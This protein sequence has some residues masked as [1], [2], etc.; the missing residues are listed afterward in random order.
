MNNDKILFKE[1]NEVKNL[2]P[3]HINKCRCENY[4]WDFSIELGE[5]VRGE[6][7]SERLKKLYNTPQTKSNYM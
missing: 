4:Y 2:I 1:Q 5:W 6:K 3:V 7:I